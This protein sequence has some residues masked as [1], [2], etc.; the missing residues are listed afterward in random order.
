MSLAL[1]FGWFNG[2]VFRLV[3]L[4]GYFKLSD[5]SSVPLFQ[6]KFS[7]CSSEKNCVH[8]TNP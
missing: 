4:A 5:K 6:V 3:L 2:V 1:P 7:N 8:T